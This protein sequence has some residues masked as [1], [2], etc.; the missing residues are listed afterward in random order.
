MRTIAKVIWFDTIK[1]CG[2]GIT[3]EEKEVREIILTKKCIVESEGKDFLEKDTLV[4][5]DLSA[6]FVCTMPDKV[7]PYALNIKT[8][9]VH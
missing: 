8:I 5:C 4:E 6:D 7:T 9:V 2:M 1:Q 3:L